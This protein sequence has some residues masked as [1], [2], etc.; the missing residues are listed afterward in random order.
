M[1]VSMRLAE[2]LQRLEGVK[3]PTHLGHYVA[4]CP[5]HDDHQPSLSLGEN[6][7][8]DVL[9]KCFAG[10]SAYEVVSAIGLDLADLFDH[11]DDDYASQSLPK[12]LRMELDAAW[13]C[14]HHEMV[15]VSLA[16]AQL[17]GGVPLSEPD[18]KR[19]LES[20]SMLTAINEAVYG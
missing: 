19:L 17:A 20:V 16:A 3:G 5:A 6:Q 18:A 14:V 7:H 1:G 9:L 8:G 13:H 12:P 2:L 4:R 10:C 11:H 15:I